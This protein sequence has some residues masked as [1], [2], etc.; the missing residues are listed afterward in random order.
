[1]IRSRITLLGKVIA[2][3]TAEFG[4]ARDREYLTVNLLLDGLPLCSPS[5]QWACVE[6]PRERA[7]VIFE[8]LWGAVLSPRDSNL[9]GAAK[10]SQREP[11]RAQ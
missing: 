8:R 9:T 10:G 11:R 6:P 2:A 5:R 7:F 1:M 3:L 4:Y